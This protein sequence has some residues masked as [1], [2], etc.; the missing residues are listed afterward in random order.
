MR[1]RVLDARC[2]LALDLVGG[3][4]AV[5]GGAERYHH[6][7]RPFLGNQVMTK[8]DYDI[9]NPPSREEWLAMDESERIAAVQEAHHRTRSPVGQSAPAHAA[10]HVVVENRLAEGHAVVVAAYD[11]FRAAGL[12]RHATIH[13]L[14]SVVTRHMLA[15][16]QEERFDPDAADH[17]SETLDPAAFKPKK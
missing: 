10:I 8:R 3:I 9:A 6:D 15:A 14:A 1:L 17:D 5:A 11:R 13:A 12:G 2:A 4:Q 16:V 7:A